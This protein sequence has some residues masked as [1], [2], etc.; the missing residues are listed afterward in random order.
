MCKMNFPLFRYIFFNKVSLLT[1]NEAISA[2]N[3]FSSDV[4]TMKMTDFPGKLDISISM[5]HSPGD[6]SRL[7]MC[8]WLWKI[9]KNAVVYAE[10]SICARSLNSW[11]WYSKIIIGHSNIQIFVDLKDERRKKVA[12]EPEPSIWI[13][14]FLT[15]WMKVF[16]FLHQKYS[17]WLCYLNVCGC[18]GSTKFLLP[19]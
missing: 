5:K 13:N 6:L 3:F 10:A 7:W 15:F 8:A 14:A 2:L 9:M 17:K 1:Q 19:I 12:L 4:G 11:I 18:L 16:K